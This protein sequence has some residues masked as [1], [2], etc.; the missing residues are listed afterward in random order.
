MAK[1]K[2]VIDPLL[3]LLRDAQAAEKFMEATETPFSRR[4]YVRAIFAYIEGAIW[5]IKRS[6][7]LATEETKTKSFSVAERALLSDAT[8]DVKNNGEVTTQTKFLRLPDNLR[9][10]IRMSNR[11]FNAGIEL[12]P[13][14][15]NWQSLIDALQVR[16]RI[17]H[18]KDLGGFDVTD[19]SDA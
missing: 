6:C 9:F 19:A 1:L 2:E 5:V 7:V 10:A 3:I 4:S 12:R 8:Y 13:G 14:E 18:S 17:T 11:L 16:H 15:K